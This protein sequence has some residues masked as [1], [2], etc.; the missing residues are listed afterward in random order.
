MKTKELQKASIWLN[1]FMLFLFSSI[2]FFSACDSNT[3]QSERDKI[4]PPSSAASGIEYYYPD[5][6]VVQ[7]KL[8]IKGYNLL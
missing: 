8:I 5:S 4:A 3:I 6:G 1:A 2:M 7:T